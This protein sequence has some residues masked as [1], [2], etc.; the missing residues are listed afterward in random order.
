L[1]QRRVT[2]AAALKAL[3]HPLRLSLLEALALRGPMTASQL[4]RLLGESPSNCSWHLRKLAEHGF[5]REARGGTGRNRPWR[6]VSEGLAWGDG[7]DEAVNAAG[8][9]L[10]DAMLE[11]EVQRFR[12]ARA[13]RNQEPEEWR[14]ATG[15]NQS[16]LWMTAE[17]ASDLLARMRELFLT[18]AD[19]V[20][21]PRSRPDGA[22]LV[23]LIGWAVPFGPYQPAASPAAGTSALS[24]H[25]DTAPTE[26]DLP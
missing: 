3:A 4:A 14:D 18:Y 8:D 13:A 11:R 20:H 17:E 6:A 26:E 21:D 25:G 2:D 1:S 5:V 16:A 7:D 24:G 22:R 9:A 19:R 12:A 23:T 15:L 10:T